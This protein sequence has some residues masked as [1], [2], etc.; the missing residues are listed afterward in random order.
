MTKL[1]YH[2]SDAAYLH[3]NMEAPI[4]TLRKIALTISIII[5]AIIA[6]LAILMVTNIDRIVKVAIERFGSDA[7]GTV[8]HVGSVKIGLS[9][10]KG[11]ISGL[12]VANPPG[13]NSPYLFSLG[14]I[15][16]TIEPRTAASGVIVIDEI[17]ITDP[18]VTYE[19]ND[20]GQAN[21]DIVKK[22]LNSAGSN[23][24]TEEKNTRG[25]EKKLRIRKIV[26]ENGTLAVHIA[27]PVDKSRT[28]T[29]NR[30][31]LRDIGGPSG[32]TADQA[33]RQVIT[34]ILSE[35]RTQAAQAGAEKLL[36]K[37]LRQMLQTK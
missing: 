8:V 16:I 1:T 15:S 19:L 30:I 4:M 37:G 26:I 28:A 24:P 34:A 35:A 6:I 17:H 31:E 2:R 25:K 18:Q 36:E 14:S 27:G 11:T 13:F 20:K 12:T 29:L 10:G 23:K 32:T 9:K 7:T 22:N 21:L 33:A 3:I 5:V